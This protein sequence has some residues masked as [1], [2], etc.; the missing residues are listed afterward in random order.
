MKWIKINE[1]VE[2]NNRENYN[3]LY[4]IAMSANDCIEVLREQIRNYAETGELDCEVAER[5]LSEYH[6]TVND[7]PVIK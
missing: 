7:N 3:R 1:S 5:A 6:S 2:D 4:K